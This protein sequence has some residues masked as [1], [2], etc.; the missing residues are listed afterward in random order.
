MNC[1]DSNL[2]SPIS[3]ELYNNFILTNQSYIMKNT[4]IKLR[5]DRM[6]N[7][8]LK[9]LCQDLVEHMKN[10]DLVAL[11][12]DK[13]Y[14]RF[15][16]HMPA[17][18]HLSRKYRKLPQT[19]DIEML[20]KKL[21]CLISAL[22]LHNKALK[23]ADFDDQ[24]KA[25]LLVHHPLHKNFKNAVHEGLLMKRGRI[26]DLLN[27]IKMDPEFKTAF[28]ELGFMRY[29]DAFKTVNE[30]IDKLKQDRN[31]QK[32]KA[33]KGIGVR[34]KEDAINEL[35]ILLKSIEIIVITNPELD[36][37]KL[38]FSMNKIMIG[39][40]AFLRNTTTRRKIRQQKAEKK[41]KDAQSSAEQESVDEPTNKDFSKSDS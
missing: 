32:S 37:G 17:L 29:V 2:Q 26:N 19:E 10:N 24:Q 5:F 21:D 28:E 31:T 6:Q 25:I 39:Y 33:P 35:Q 15:A 41:A 18:T 20:R 34:T 27:W 40:R 3:Y 1:T 4:F 11:Q 13:T 16:E 38:I 30:R 8:Q 9:S 36:Y 14:Q 23:R 22:L 12:L 7:I